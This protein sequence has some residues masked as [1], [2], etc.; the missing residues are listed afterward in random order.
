MSAEQKILVALS[1][2]VDSAVAALKL[3]NAGYEVAGVYM[4]TWFAEGKTTLFS[5]CPWE[6]DIAAAKAVAR[7]LNIDFEVI[8][9]L[10]QYRERV[11]SYMVEGYRRGIT[12]NPDIMCNR[13]I[14]FGV[15]MEY[16]QECGFD[17][18]ATGHYCRLQP[19]SDGQLAIFEGVDKD[20][21]QSYFLSMVQQNQIQKA[22]FPVGGMKKTQVRELA[23]AN[24][25]PNAE[26]K[27]SQGICFLGKVSVQKFL[28]QYIEE[29]PGPIVRQDDGVVLGQ[30]KGLHNFTL[31]QRRGIGIP[32]NRDHQHYVV[33]S[34][35]YS[36]NQLFVAIENEQTPGLYQNR[37]TVHN[38]NWINGQPSATSRLSARPR[39][40]DEL[41]AIDIKYVKGDRAEVLFKN[42]QR[43]LATGQILA[44]YDGQQ[45]LG[46]GCYF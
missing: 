31:G 23:L 25:L 40:R 4:R 24:H 16:A 44:F 28:S 42:R 12:P 33:V 45:L 18:L 46:G 15:L 36:N 11:V 32:S 1:G 14:K 7:H 21:D 9:L 34:K 22:H 30:H 26:R 20:K 8:N 27:D 19:F 10:D 29:R 3:K 39:Y 6:A 38:L 2:G 35:D 41:Q 37:V 13:E 5:D 43:A 17:G